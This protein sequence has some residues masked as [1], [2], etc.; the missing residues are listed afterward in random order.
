MRK[1]AYV[2][3]LLLFASTGCF[4]SHKEVKERQVPSSHTTIEHRSSVES[5]PSADE[6]VIHKRSS[7]E[8]TY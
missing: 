8:T 6:E 1:T 5:V 2:T 4:I 7:V 3:T